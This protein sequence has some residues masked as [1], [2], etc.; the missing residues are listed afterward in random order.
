[1]RAGFFNAFQFIHRKLLSEGAQRTLTNLWI[2]VA[3]KIT[4]NTSPMRLKGFTFRTLAFVFLF[5]KD[6]RFRTMTAIRFHIYNG[7]SRTFLA[8]LINQVEVFVFIA[9]YTL[10][11]SVQWKRIWAN[12][13]SF[14]VLDFLWSY[15]TGTARFSLSVIMPIT[16]NTLSIFQYRLSIRTLALMRYFWKYL[17][18]KVTLAWIFLCVRAL[19]TFLTFFCLTV[20]NFAFLTLP[21][22][23]V[24][25]FGCLWG[26]NAF[27]LSHIEN[28]CFWTVCWQA[29]VYLRIVVVVLRTR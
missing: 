6:E 24:S 3:R 19:W 4:G 15:F 18:F 17:I 11:S 28:I 25:L 14:L 2:K 20:V 5:V 23:I 8:L 22:L 16:W 21:A 13:F 27:F 12:T 29:F 7:S 1:M 26:A 10:W 9:F